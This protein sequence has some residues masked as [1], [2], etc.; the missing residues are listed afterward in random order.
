MCI[1][2]A[3]VQQHPEYP[4]II[5]A[6]RDEFYARPTAPSAFWTEPPGLL[7]GKDLMAGGTWMG[8]TRNGHIAALTNIRNPATQSDD[9]LSRGHL[10]VKYLASPPL[11]AMY[12]RTLEA[13]ANQYNGFN[14]LF[15]HYRNLLAFNSESSAH[16]WLSPGVHSLSNASLNTPW[17]K[18]R[19]GTQALQ[20]YIS[21][22]DSLNI[23]H[24]FAL[25]RNNQQA[26]MDE[27]PST[28][29]SPE[30]EMALS[31][32]FI[33]TPKYGTRSSTILLVN[34]HQ[35]ACWYECTYTSD[36]TVGQMQHFSWKIG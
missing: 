16:E 15:G 13:T 27:L 32:I 31:P 30:W 21:S 22:A 19:N 3:A 7:A 1:I 26:P 18:V 36:G 12:L 5:A 8:I 6:N 11:S 4:L 10:V 28:G 24:L 17:P 29:V 2:F 23:D 25:L 35:Q 14:M 9:K 34:Q 20:E 33:H